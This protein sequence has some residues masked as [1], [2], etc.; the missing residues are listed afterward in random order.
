MIKQRISFP[1]HLT[2]AHNKVLQIGLFGFG[3]VGEGLYKVLQQTPSLNAN[4]LKVC[5]KNPDKKRNAPEQL[6]TTERDELLNDPDIN[7][8]V[9][10]IDD[11]DAAYEIISTAFK[12]GKDE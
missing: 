3:V 9:E 10:V 4:I 6:F 1:C 7:V 8:I 5:I 12:N 2:E 11:S